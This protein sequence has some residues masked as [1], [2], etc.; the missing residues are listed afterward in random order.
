M[1]IHMVLL[2]EYRVLVPPQFSSDVNR[3]FTKVCFLFLAEFL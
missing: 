1:V 3:Q 2:P